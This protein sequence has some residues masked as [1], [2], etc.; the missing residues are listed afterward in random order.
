MFKDNTEAGRVIQCIFTLP[1]PILILLHTPLCSG[2]AR[3]Q[4]PG[5]VLFQLKILPGASLVNQWLRRVC[6]A[7][8]GAG[9]QSVIWENPTCGEAARPAR[10]NH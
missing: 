8:Q 10:C 1:K 3:K 9:V 7:I 2:T 5:T 6:L 4:I